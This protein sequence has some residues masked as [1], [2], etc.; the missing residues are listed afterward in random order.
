MSEKTSEEGRIPETFTLK[1]DFPDPSLEA[2]QREAEKALGGKS[3]ARLNRPTHEGIVV[4]PLYLPPSVE[5]GEAEDRNEMPLFAR[6]AGAAPGRTSGPAICQRL[7][8]ARA[9]DCSRMA[10]EDIRHSVDA[11]WLVTDGASQAGLDPW[12]PAAQAMSGPGLIWSRNSDLQAALEGIDLRRTSLHLD[13]GAGA[14]LAAAALAA[15][16]LGKSSMREVDGAF[17]FDPLGALAL[18]GE[19]RADLDFYAHQMADLANW[20]SREAPRIRAVSVSS[21]PYHGSGA[22]A[23]QELAYALATGVQYLRDLEGHGMEAVRACSQLL[24]VLAVGRDFFMEIAKLRAVRQIWTLALGT[25]GLPS[26]SL[27]MRLQAVTSPRTLTVRDPWVN[28]MRAASESFAAFA[29]GADLLTV[30]PLDT[31]IGPSNSLAR[32][33]AANTNTILAEESSLGR[34]ADPAGGSWYVEELTEQLAEKAWDLFREIEAQG[35]MRRMLLEGRIAQ[36]LES[37][38]AAKRKAINQRRDPITGVSQYADLS[39]EPLNRPGDDLGQLRRSFQPPKEPNPEVIAA[40]QR[41]GR[42]S[43]EGAG[44]G[45]VFAAAVEA[46]RAGACLGQVSSALHPQ[47]RGVRIDAMPLRREAE[48]FECLRSRLD[49]LTSALGRR[50]KVFLANLGPLAGHKPRS[51]FARGFVEA[52]GLEAE[53]SQGFEDVESLG[54]AFAESPAEIAV[55]CGPDDLYPSMAPQAAAVL[56]ERGALEVLLAGRPGKKEDEFRQAGID[57]FIHIGCDALAILEDLVR[58]LE[59]RAA[60]EACRIPG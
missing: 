31:A 54:G 48:E 15:A 8:Y 4:R 29:G 17:H 49:G 6:E 20:C 34:V 50:P 21:L 59:E 38:A 60:Q 37:T 39:E 57:R 12:D 5:A 3:L 42:A 23:V 25:W 52:A 7:D 27:A 1:E 41:V 2:W 22:S 18:Q 30:L 51:L 11:L 9:R 53:G 36:Q 16:V 28:L 44:D 47:E 24:F 26:E 40:L 35:G 33:L 46:F 19:L 56:K 13:A 58:K 45:R 14:F 43:R 55:L 32:R 10:Q